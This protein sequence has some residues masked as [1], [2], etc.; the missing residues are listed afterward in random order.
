MKEARPIILVA[1]PDGCWRENLRQGL[2]AHELSSVPIQ[3]GADLSQE[4][5]DRT[6]RGIVAR[7]DPENEA[8]LT[9]WLSALRCSRP[10]WAIVALL[11]SSS[12]QSL[13]L[14]FRA[15]A[16]D[17][18]EGSPGVEELISIL[19]DAARIRSVQ[20][21]GLCP[22]S[23]VQAPADGAE[24]CLSCLESTRAL[25]AAVEAKDLH[26]RNHSVTVSRYATEIGRRIGLNGPE[27]AHLR[28]AALLHD[29]GKIGVPDDILAK[30]GPLTNTE[31]EIVK[32]HPE[33]AL[34]ILGHLR[35]LK[36]ERSL[37]LHHHERYDGRGYP[38]ALK[39]EHIP[40]GA[41]IL[42]VADSIDAMFSPRSY[43]PPYP[44]RQV[45][46]ELFVGLG[47]QFDPD[48]GRCAID[49]LEN[50]PEDF[51]QRTTSGAGAPGYANTCGR[52][53]LVAKDQDAT[54]FRSTVGSIPLLR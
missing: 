45:Q 9:L 40:L 10:D 50:S 42:A 46:R 7:I 47:L 25:V 36:D 2:A 30:P 22:G 5:A 43:K 6:V 13:R 1:H 11:P 49:W 4:L 33:I 28:A 38:A 51:A 27:I 48:I 3:P 39:G 41:R 21:G 29:V 53:G 12:A 26:T 35:N 44:L 14:V 52:C 37:I 19:G 34:Q 31:Y 24:T 15:G 54:N 23:S 32:R 17:C 18:M 20:C 8:D 16:D